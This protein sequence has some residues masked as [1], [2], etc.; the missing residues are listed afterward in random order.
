MSNAQIYKIY[1]LS[2]VAT[3][4]ML[5]LF[6]YLNANYDGQYWQQLQQ[7]KSALTAEYCELDKSTH[8]FRQTINTYSNLMYFFL[9]CI[10][11][12][13]GKHDLKHKAATP[14]NAIQQFPA[15]SILIGMCFIYLCLG[16]SFFHASLSWIGQRLDMNATYSICIVLIGI[17]I[18]RYFES[19]RIRHLHFIFLLIA[20]IIAFIKIHLMISS[21]VLLPALILVLIGF[22][23][24]NYLRNKSHYHFTTLVLSF[25]F[26]IGA[27]VLRTIDL[28]K[29][30]C[31]PISIYQGHALWHFFTG[32][33]AF[34]LYWFYRNEKIAS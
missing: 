26:L 33:S 32:I 5:L 12:L 28:K 15:I 23:T 30:A 21:F 10:V 16:S 34:L 11:L 24:A 6:F 1:S 4:F 29:I 9:G 14:M 22:T 18:F 2:A 3:L 8:F 19:I 25:F 7:S 13:I 17:S 27:F 31:N 20:C